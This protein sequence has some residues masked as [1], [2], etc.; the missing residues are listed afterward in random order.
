MGTFAFAA[1]FSAACFAL[2]APNFLRPRRG[3][4]LSSSYRYD[5]RLVSPPA[6][7]L[8]GQGRMASLEAMPPEG[9]LS[10]DE[11]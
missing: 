6:E 5:V 2:T 10:V 1:C 4:S 9:G 7:S 3:Q 8:T 11:R